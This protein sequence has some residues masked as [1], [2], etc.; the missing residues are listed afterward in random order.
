MP[1]RDMDRGQMWLLPPTLEDLLPPDHPAR[2]VA[3]FVD[4]LE[5]S[6]LNIPCKDVIA[7]EP[8]LTLNAI[9]G[10]VPPHGL[11]HIWHSANDQVVKPAPDVTFPARHGRDIGLHRG[12]AVP[13]RNLR[14]ATR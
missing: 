3:E 9:E 5:E 11:P 13:L 6:H 1:L 14:V 4:A 2:F 8:A 10:R 12:V 7:Q